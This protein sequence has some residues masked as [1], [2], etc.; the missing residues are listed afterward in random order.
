MQG[1]AGPGVQQA[2]NFAH[3]IESIAGG[4]PPVPGIERIARGGAHNGLT[5]PGSESAPKQANATRVGLGGNNN[6]GFVLP[7]GENSRDGSDFVDGI[8]DRRFE[9]V[10]RFQRDSFVKENELAVIVLPGERN[11]QAFQSFG[12]FGGVGQPDFRR[13]SRAV[14][15]RGF[16]GAQR[17]RAAEHH[18]RSGFHERVFQHQPAAETEKDYDG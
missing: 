5:V 17:H 11:A 7:A 8:H 16:H 14:K 18:D 9:D 10:N 6:D 4:A 13:V 12:G 3:Y 15:F 2:Q 1:Q